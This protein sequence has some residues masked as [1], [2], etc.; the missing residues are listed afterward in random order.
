MGKRKWQ[1]YQPHSAYSPTG[2]SVRVDIG[3]LNPGA[4][5][6]RHA[7]N[8]KWLQRQVGGNCWVSVQPGE[9]VVTGSDPA[10]VAWA[11]ALLRAQV[12]ANVQMGNT[13]Y[14]YPSRVDSFLFES[15]FGPDPWSV[16]FEARSA[17]DEA[18]R[19]AGRKEQLYVM[20]PRAVDDLYGGSSG[21]LPG[22][23]GGPSLRACAFHTGGPALGPNGPGAAALSAAA[24]TAAAQQT[25]PLSL[26]CLRFGLG[27]QFFFNLPSVHCMTLDQLQ[28]LYGTAGV[29]QAVFSN[30]FPSPLVAPLERWLTGEGGL[31]FVRVKAEEVA[32]IH[33]VNERLNIKYTVDVVFDSDGTTRLERMRGAL[34]VLHF[35]ALL[36]GP[37]QL[38]ARV[39][40]IGRRGERQM[41]EDPTARSVAA[42][43]VAACNG[44]GG[45]RALASAPGRHLP[46]DMRLE[47]SRRKSK[48]A[49]EGIL[50]VPGGG[51]AVRLRVTIKRV[52]EEQ[53]GGGSY[54]E[55]AGSIPD[56]DSELAELLEVG[57]GGSGSGGGGSGPST[58]GGSGS[59]G[60]SNEGSGSGGGGGHSGRDSGSDRPS[61][62]SSG[63]GGGGGRTAARDDEEDQGDEAA[64]PSGD[65]ASGRKSTGSSCEVGCKSGGVIGR[66]LCDAG[67]GARAAAAFVEAANAALLG[68]G[69]A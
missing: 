29:S 49:Y 23:G 63:S 47:T 66:W 22:L 7:S 68:E 37:R 36:A 69:E 42:A 35:A 41:H 38:D 11:A 8:V 19:A 64:G 26:L 10:A 56:L 2:A 14:P 44:A 52:Q 40:L 45:L 58:D 62:H 67:W 65:D 34:D 55:V 27:K 15:A 17:A 39:K 3:S 61:N 53:P 43:V 6:G 12:E 4:I 13:A 30:A 20:A 9:A 32:T 24:R 5:I 25:P 54:T 46:P 1:K 60:R 31:G 59:G 16:R 57:G 33:I 51:R 18:V 48:A 28:G 21:A 50:Q